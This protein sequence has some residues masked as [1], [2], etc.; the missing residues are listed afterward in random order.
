MP[1]SRTRKIIAIG[2]KKKANSYPFY[3]DKEV[4]R[5]KPKVFKMLRDNKDFIALVRIGRCLNV[6][7]YSYQL[8]KNPLSSLPEKLQ[9][10]HRVRTLFNTAGYLAEGIKVAESLRLAYPNDEFFKPLCELFGDSFKGHR[11]IVKAIR[12]SAFH[13]DH[14]AKSTAATLKGLKLPYYDFYSELRGEVGSIYFH[15]P[16][17]VDLNFLM[18]DLMPNRSDRVAVEELHKAILEFHIAFTGAALIFVKGVL[19]KLDLVN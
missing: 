16:D 9:A 17:V 3:M 5:L 4:V 6:L 7:D 1:I 13:L 18:N 11:D 14:E 8:I 15:L 19:K 2:R 12:N 10:H